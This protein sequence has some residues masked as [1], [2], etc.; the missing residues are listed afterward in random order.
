MS[1]DMAGASGVETIAPED[2]NTPTEAGP[3]AAAETG[4]IDI[5]FSPGLT[6]FLESS[7][8]ALGFT[9]Y[10]TGRL[11]LI[12]HGPDGKLALHE[13]VY[14]QAMGLTGDA[15]R[16]YLGT[17]TQIVRMENVLAPGQRANQ[18][19]DKVYVP[20]NLQ[21]TG[22]VDIHELG[23]R[24]NGRI[25]FVN[26]RY[27]CL[28]EPSLTHSFKPVWKPDFI[29]RLVPEDRC[30]L[31]GLAMVD[32]KPK[33]VSAVSRSDTLDGWREDRD[34]GGLIID[35]ESAAIIGEGLSMP[36]SPRRLRPAGLFPRLSARA[37]VSR[38][39]CLRHPVETAARPF[40]GSGAG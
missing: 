30:H 24:D 18:V 31:N 26:T 12:G 10:Q 17:L 3:T 22:N 19:H 25:L 20:R 36:P 14:P 34:E 23:I 21:T 16:I 6:E 40:R 9:S 2:R 7:N 15:S 13:A 28:C 38:T 11:Y 4:T 37:G 32:G 1:K 35:V 27:N 8:I 33:Y 5:S 39:S 29:S